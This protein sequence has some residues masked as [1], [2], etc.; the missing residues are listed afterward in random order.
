MQAHPG[1]ALPP[2]ATSSTRNVR[3]RLDSIETLP[4]F[5]PAPA[6]A[7]LHVELPSDVGPADIMSEVEVNTYIYTSN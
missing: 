2:N 1:I 4:Q 7:E 5:P 6:P 3:P